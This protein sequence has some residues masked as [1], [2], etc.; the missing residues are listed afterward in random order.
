MGLATTSV[1]LWILFAIRRRRRQSRFENDTAMV[2]SHATPTH[3]SLLGDDDDPHQARFSASALDI[4]QQRSSS[5]LASTYFGTRVSYHDDPDHAVESFNPYTDY[6]YPQPMASSPSK[7]GYVPAPT[8]SPPAAIINSDH[9]RRASASGSLGSLSGQEGYIVGTHSTTPSGA[10]YEPLMASYHRQ[11]NGSN[12]LPGTPVLATPPATAIPKAQPQPPSDHSSQPL[13]DDRGPIE[14]TEPTEPTE[15]HSIFASDDRLDPGL[16][17]RQRE[18]D[19]ASMKD[20]KDEEDYS[21]PV[22]G[23]RIVS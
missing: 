8:S 22:L 21:R 12:Q 23:V 13:L 5:A 15:A 6:G 20:L 3:R 7:D 14:S 4:S 10:S 18:A 19:S 1:A 11:S 17:Q 9:S 2:P 16:R